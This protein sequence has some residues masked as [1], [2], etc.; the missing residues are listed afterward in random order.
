MRRAQ[1]PHERQIGGQ[2]FA[3][4]DNHLVEV[5]VR[6]DERGGVRL[7]DVSEMRGGKPRAQRVNGGR[8]EHDIADLAE[9]DQE[10]PSKLASW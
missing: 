6:C 10:N 3:R 2:S 8:R 7:D 4:G 9:P 1:P 5:R